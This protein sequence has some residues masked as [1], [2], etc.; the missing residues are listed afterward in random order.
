MTHEFLVYTK[1]DQERAYTVKAETAEGAQLKLKAAL[2]EDYYDIPFL[3]D[4]SDYGTE[5]LSGDV[6]QISDLDVC[7]TKENAK[8]P[9]FYTKEDDGLSLPWS[10]MNW[11]NPPYSDIKRWAQQARREQFKGHTT[12]MLMP[13]RTD[14]VFFHDHIYNQ[15]NVD[16]RFVKGRWKFG[17]GKN[18]APFPSM[19][20]IF[21][22][23]HR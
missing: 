12:V 21:R 11:C 8:C 19:L 10:K 14:T 7:A 20:V 2:E 13:A 22:P 6:T 17:D 3:M 18:S 1:I 15:P 23:Y 16:V 4:I 9:K 5:E